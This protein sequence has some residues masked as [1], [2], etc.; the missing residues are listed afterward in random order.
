[1]SFNV[2][3]CKI[4][5]V[6]HRN[7]HFE[8]SMNGERLE[9]ASEE[10]DLGVWVEQSLK[11]G[12]QCAAAAK[13]AHFALG[14]IQRSFHFRSKKNLIPLFKTFVRPKVE[15]AISAWNPW[16]AGDA[17]L[18]EKVQ[19]RLIRLLS[20]VKGNTYEERV[21]DAGLTTLGDRRKRGDLIETFKVLNGFSR[22]NK[23]EWFKIVPDEAR[24][25]RRTASV[26]D[27]GVEERRKNV[28]EQEGARLEVR[29]NFFNVRV[30]KEWNSL[31][32]KV[33]ESPTVNSFKNSYDRW[34]KTKNPNHDGSTD[35]V[36]HTE[37]TIPE[38]RSVSG[39]FSINN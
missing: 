30:P 19:E 29:R 14:Q 36:Q 25:T 22:V 1:M 32:D 39:Q 28:L 13:A 27:V 2:K 34:I 35:A 20:D 24:P 33:K 5:H 31:P 26:T 37:D 3:K 7:R 4:M 38:E 23:D 6:G 9:T 21:K 17:K 11:P 15:F 16:L 18:L 12:K 8:Y 10:K